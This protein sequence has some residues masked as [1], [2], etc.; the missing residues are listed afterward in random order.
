V[1]QEA[2][3]RE[4]TALA[5]GGFSGVAAQSLARIAPERRTALFERASDDA[6]AADLLAQ[7]LERLG[8]EDSLSR[9]EPPWRPFR[10]GSPRLPRRTGGARRRGRREATRDRDV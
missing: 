9:P 2:I 1:T 10:R 5:R 6:R 4:W 3:A 7:A 8:V